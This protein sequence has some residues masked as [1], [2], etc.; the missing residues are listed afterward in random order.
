MNDTRY[1]EIADKLEQA[2]EA[3]LEYNEK[4][5]DAGDAYSHCP[6][7]GSYD[8]NDGGRRLKEFLE[9]NSID[10]QGVDFDVLQGFVLDNFEMLAG[11]IYGCYKTT[12][13]RMDGTSSHFE[14]CS[15]A[16]QEVEDQ[17][18]ADCPWTLDA[19]GLESVEEFNEFAKLADEDARFCLRVSE[20]EILSYTST[21]AVWFAAISKESICE[22]IADTVEEMQTS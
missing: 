10:L 14:L 7:E 21:D 22:F 16:V 19:L 3:S 18:C 17:F 8:Y 1:N 6:Y 15:F 11:S 4:H 5:G 2:I 9:A 13:N 12:E 20:G